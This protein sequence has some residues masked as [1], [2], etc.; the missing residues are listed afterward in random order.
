MGKLQVVPRYRLVDGQVLQHEIVVFAVEGE[1]ALRVPALRGRRNRIERLPVLFQRPRRV[2]VGGGDAPAE[3]GHH[4]D[5]QRLAG[6]GDDSVRPG[7][8]GD[9]GQILPGVFDDRRIRGMGVRQ[10]IQHCPDHGRPVGQRVL[11]G[12]GA[13]LPVQRQG[14]P[15]QLAL[16]LRQLALGALQD[17]LHRKVGMQRVG[18]L[19]AVFLLADA[20]RAGRARQEFFAQPAAVLLQRLQRSLP[21]RGEFVLHARG[22]RDEIVEIAG[23]QGDD[24]VVLPDG[25]LGMD[26]RRIGQIGAGC[27]Q[28]RRDRL[29]PL[30]E[31]G[32]ALLQ[33]GEL[34]RQQRV[35]CIAHAVAHGIPFV[36]PQHRG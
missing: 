7:E 36:L 17:L 5:P 11:V 31:T 24:A 1:L 10:R 15:V 6:D 30:V 21:S 26:P 35:Q 3:F 28:C 18:E 4:D 33:R 13:E 34:A 2:A 8:F 12:S 23:H 25:R 29:E 19:G 20:E 16:Q 32:Q 9:L 22:E 14:G 27:G